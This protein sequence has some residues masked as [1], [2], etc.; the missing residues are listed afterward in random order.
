[1]RQLRML[2][3]PPARL[4]DGQRVVYSAHQRQSDV[5]IVQNFDGKR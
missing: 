2:D 5:W 3:T 4:G 1:M